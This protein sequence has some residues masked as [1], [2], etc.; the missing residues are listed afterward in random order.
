V[1]SA[2]ADWLDG[3]SPDGELIGSMDSTIPTLW[4]PIRTSLLFVSRA[5]FGTSTETR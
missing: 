5:A 2:A 1:A 4:P 3:G